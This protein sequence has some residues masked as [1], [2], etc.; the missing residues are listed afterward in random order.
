MKEQLHALGTHITRLKARLDT[1]VNLSEKMS[2]ATANT[3]TEAERNAIHLKVKL[4]KDDIAHQTSNFR[5]KMY[6]F[7]NIVTKISSQL[8]ERSSVI[9]AVCAESN[10]AEHT[11]L[12]EVF[13]SEH[14]ELE[15]NLKKSLAKVQI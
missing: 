8:T 2:S 14:V 4:V 9:E 10:M 3:F 13:E 1:L 7:E 6:I 5:E 15:S 12:M 11:D